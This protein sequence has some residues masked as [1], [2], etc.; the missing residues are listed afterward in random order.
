MTKAG[1]AVWTPCHSSLANPLS[2]RPSRQVRRRWRLEERVD[3]MDCGGGGRS[4]RRCSSHC[5]GRLERGEKFASPLSSRTEDGRLRLP[6][7][8]SSTSLHT[9]TVLRLRKCFKSSIRRITPNPDCKCP[10]S[11]STQAATSSYC[12]TIQRFGG[13]KCKA[14]TIF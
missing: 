10:N 13:V 14:R 8:G 11:Q 1:G 5:A 2:P 3:D 9:W 12:Q 7:T 4:R 6:T